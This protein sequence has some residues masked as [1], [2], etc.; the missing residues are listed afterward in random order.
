[1]NLSNKMA[2]VVELNDLDNA[3]LSVNIIYFT[4]KDGESI[5]IKFNDDVAEVMFAIFKRILNER[6]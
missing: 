2:K 3:N 1:M 5:A 6:Q 4:K